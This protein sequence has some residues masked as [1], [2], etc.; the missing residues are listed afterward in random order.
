MFMKPMAITIIV[1]S[2]LA[3]ST[4]EG[5]KNYNQDNKT[6][7]TEQVSQA[8]KQSLESN[9]EAVPNAVIVRVPVDNNGQANGEPEMRI[10]EGEGELADE[11]GVSQAFAVGGAPEQVSENSDELDSDS[12]TQ[13][14]FGYRGCG[15]GCNYG[16]Q[17]GHNYWY[18]QF[19]P[20]LQ[21]RGVQWQYGYHNQGFNPYHCRRGNYRYYTY[22][23]YRHWNVF[24]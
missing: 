2:A 5:Q 16:N 1:S 21:W 20:R 24:P 10:Y 4:D 14:W 17:Y 12:S 3:C 7:Q 15:N 23:S 6:P 13:S 22:H 8:E 19:R 18:N 11:E 9:Y